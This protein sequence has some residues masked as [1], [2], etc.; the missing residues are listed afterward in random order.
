MGALS[1]GG[2]VVENGKERASL[3]PELGE[4]THETPAPHAELPGLHEHRE[5]PAYGADAGLDG[6][7]PNSWHP[8]QALGIVPPDD[9]LVG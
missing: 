5:E 9:F 3:D 8:P 1:V 7:E 4:E 6:L 2:K